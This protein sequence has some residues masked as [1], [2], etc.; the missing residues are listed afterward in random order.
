MSV[1][2]DYVV[3]TALRFMKS[4]SRPRLLDFGCGGAQVLAKALQSGIDAWGV[5]RFAPDWNELLAKPS[6]EVISRVLTLDDSGKLPFPDGH[7]EVVAANM[8]FE[9]IDDFSGPLSE[10]RRVLVPNGHV[11]LIFPT[12]ELWHENH[13][14]LPFAH[15]FAKGSTL[16]RRY[17]FAA[18]KAGLGRSREDLPRQMWVAN[19]ERALDD[20]TFYKTYRA[21]RYAIRRGGFAIEETLEADHL[22]YRSL[23]TLRSPALSRLMHH[24]VARPVFN[25]LG[26]RLLFRVL[27]L[28]PVGGGDFQAQTVDN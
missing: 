13:V 3:D 27:H 9:H 4:Q 21:V 11:L 2:Y 24:P 26:S 14:G 12:M 8:V 23:R 10:I 25:Y 5:D 17:M 16:R 6:P 1:N 7:F 18:H 15:R 19:M 22:A 20:M 28:R